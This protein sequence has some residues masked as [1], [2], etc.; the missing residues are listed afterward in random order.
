[1]S[2]QHEPPDRSGQLIFTTSNEDV[3]SELT[4]LSLGSEDRVL[5]I[6]ASGSRPLELLAA[7]PREIVAIDYNPA[8][9]F[10]LELT[11]AAIRRLEHAEFLQFLGVMPSDDRGATYRALREDLGGEARAF[12]DGEAKRIK[13]GIVYSGRWERLMWFGNLARRRRA[14]QLINCT[15][16]DEQRRFWAER[17]ATRW[18]H[19]RQHLAGKRWIW[20]Y[21]IRE[22]GYRHIPRDFDV[23]EYM[24]R[25][26]SQA[27]YTKLLRD[28]PLAW[29]IYLGRYDPA[30]ALPPY[31]QAGYYPIMRERM[32][33]IRI[34]TDS[35]SRYLSGDSGSF[36][37][38]SISDFS[39][40]ADLGTYRDVWTGL[41]RK[42]TAGARVCERQFLVKR[43]PSGVL[44][45]E[46][47]RDAEIE[48]RLELEDNALFYTFVVGR[49]H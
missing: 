9:S 5:C 19:R 3:S 43:D 49:L 1:M 33:C 22:E 11:V 7:G 8:Q 38:Y 46:L 17:W 37:A 41:A 32:S 25:R 21:L 30:V 16:L 6:T 29:L 45:E 10:L 44:G 20:E 4:A 34:V 18:W 39:S 2:R 48:A 40:Y 28:C 14:R 23:P 42:A 35:L 36:D 15:G 12:W 27:A 13:N 24:I 47:A 26:L 31:L